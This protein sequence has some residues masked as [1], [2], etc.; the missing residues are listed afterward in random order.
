MHKGRES[1]K[2]AGGDD[3]RWL[4]SGCDTRS[5]PPPLREKWRAM[6]GIEVVE[7]VSVRMFQILK[8]KKA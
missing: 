4:S 8:K 6:G 3:G 2:M 5:V 1:R 7:V